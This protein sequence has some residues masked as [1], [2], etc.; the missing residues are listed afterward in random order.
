MAEHQGSP[1]LKAAWLILAIALAAVLIPAAA[2]AADASP[3]MRITAWQMD[4]LR[5]TEFSTHPIAK[6]GDD[7]YLVRRIRAGEIFERLVQ[8]YCDAVGLD[9]EKCKG[10]AASAT[11]L[12]QI[13]HWYK[14]WQVDDV[15]YL[16]VPREVYE[17]KSPGK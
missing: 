16:L 12:H 6:K 8:A 10:V 3:F 7:Y 11:E 13:A 14:N 5:G 9:E 17:T 1:G 4:K 15:L 2:R